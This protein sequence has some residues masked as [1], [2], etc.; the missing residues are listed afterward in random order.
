MH[1]ARDKR[2]WAEAV[3]DALG[4]PERWVCSL[5][6]TADWETA[7]DAGL[8]PEQAVKQYI[9]L[10]TLRGRL[11]WARL[12]A[13][14]TLGQCMHHSEVPN[15]FERYS[16]AKIE[17]FD[18]AYAA[19][20]RLHFQSGLQALARLYSVNAQW[21]ET[22][23]GVDIGPEVE[24]ALAPLPESLRLKTRERLERYTLT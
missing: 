16:E 7:F 4:W 10:T 6:E 11:I 2:V 3:C 8:S 12:E 13:R 14:M 1:N 21:L 20:T 19:Q 5:H 17:T 23:V 22:G 9:D 15:L 24:A 18:S